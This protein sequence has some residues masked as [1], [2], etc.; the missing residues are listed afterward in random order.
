M[1]PPKSDDVSFKEHFEERLKA[2]ERLQDE[3]WKSHKEVHDMGQ[4]AFDAYQEATSVKLHDV[5]KLRDQT[6]ADRTDFLRRD[7]YE[8]EHQALELKLE[9]GLVAQATKT[10]AH[11]KWIDGM[12]GKLIGAGAVILALASLIAWLMPHPWGK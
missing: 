6:I 10:D 7:I 11:G 3:R 12:T 5:N 8:R 1:G 4:R 2:L 9:Q